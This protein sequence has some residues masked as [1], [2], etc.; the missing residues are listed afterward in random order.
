MATGFIHLPALAWVPADGSTSNA[1]PTPRR[2]KSTAAAPSLHFV[3]WQFADAVKAYLYA[4]FR[5]PADYASA[6]ILRVDGKAN[7]T[8]GVAVLS[9]R[10]AAITAG[11]VDT[12]NE[13]A[14]GTDNTTTWT[15]NATEARRLVQA[16]VTLTN[17]D[18]AAAGDLIVL[19]FARLGDDASDTLTVAFEFL[20]GLLEYTTT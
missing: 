4:T 13:K 11:D 14:L 6:P 9:S 15:A 16:S 2:I 8:S 3:E 5:M 20:G 10:V 19:E 12:P 7:A 1:A 17:A 18:S